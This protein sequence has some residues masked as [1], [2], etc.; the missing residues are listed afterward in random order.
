MRAAGVL[1]GAVA[2]A[3]AAGHERRDLLV[4]VV[5]EERGR[6]HL[7]RVVE[8]AV[9]RADLVGHHLL[10]RVRVAGREAAGLVARVAFRLLKAVAGGSPVETDVARGLGESRGAILRNAVYIGD[11]KV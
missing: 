6:I 1:Y 5:V 7:Q 2:D 10:R 3:H 4:L 8:R 11:L 9:F